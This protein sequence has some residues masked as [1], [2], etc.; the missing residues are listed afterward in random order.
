MPGQTQFKSDDVIRLMRDSKDV[1]ELVYNTITN[2]LAKCDSVKKNI[3]EIAR[4]IRKGIGLDITFIIGEGFMDILEVCSLAPA[5]IKRALRSKRTELEA[6]MIVT[7]KFPPSLA[8]KVREFLDIFYACYDYN[9][10][11][12]LNEQLKSMVALETVISQ[13]GEELGR[14]GAKGAQNENIN[15]LRK[16]IKEVNE[17]DQGDDD[18]AEMFGGKDE[19]NDED[20]EEE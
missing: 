8:K 5:D 16:E 19:G 11:L 12:I 6:E 14:S 7:A 1:A 9:Y 2:Q 17:R 18:F 13:A 10:A 3:N 15:Q 4:N 20:E